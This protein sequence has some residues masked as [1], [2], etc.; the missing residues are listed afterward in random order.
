MAGLALALAWAAVGA[1][2]AQ[3]E[4]PFRFYGM[5][6]DG[7]EV[8]IST[9]HG[10]EL[11]RG[12]VSGGVWYVDVDRDEANGAQFSLNGEAADAEITPTGAGQASVVLTPA[13]VEEPVEETDDAMMGEDGMDE[14]GMEEDAMEEDVLEEETDDSMMEEDADDSMME[15]DADDS[16]MEEDADD[17]MMEETPSEDATEP[18]EDGM[19]DESPAEGSEEEEGAD[20]GFPGTGTGGLAAA[21]SQADW[22]SVLALAAVVLAA[23]IGWRWARRRA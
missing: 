21:Q 5:G 8:V 7:D 20:V 2:G 6:T 10:A 12:M 16:M 1:A 17:S 19:M 11:G 23:G 22:T 9:E 18:V 13:V 3:Q 14:D 15:E 4:P